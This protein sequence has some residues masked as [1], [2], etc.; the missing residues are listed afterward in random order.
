MPTY[1]FDFRTDG[2]VFRDRLGTKYADDESARSSMR[3]VVFEL[4]DTDYANA[5]EYAVILRRE[6]L[7]LSSLRMTFSKEDLN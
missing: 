3:E 4:I 7:T 1:F 2:Y 6:C 5:G